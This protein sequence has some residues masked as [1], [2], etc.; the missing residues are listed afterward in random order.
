[1]FG[2]SETPKHEHYFII[3]MKELEDLT[4]LE[5][6]VLLV[7]C[8]ANIF[9]LSSHI[10]LEAVKRRLRDLSPKLVKKAINLL[11]T[12]GFIMKHPTRHRIT[13]QLTKKGLHSGNQIKLGISN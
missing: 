10:P 6:E 12:N 11:L 3:I 1:M 2:N 4:I 8:D 9:S 7:F 5:R 13:Y